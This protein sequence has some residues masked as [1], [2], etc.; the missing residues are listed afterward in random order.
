MFEN[1]I[2]NDIRQIRRQIEKDCN[3]DGELY[4]EYLLE[5]QKKYAERLIRRK[6]NLLIRRKK[7]ANF[8]PV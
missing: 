5:I 4:Y 3:N 7:S 6:P 8:S 1:P 2:I